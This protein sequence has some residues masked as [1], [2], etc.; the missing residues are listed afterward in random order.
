MAIRRYRL[1][2]ATDTRMAIPYTAAKQEFNLP[3]TEARTMI[4]STVAC[5]HCTFFMH[6]TRTTP[7]H[8]VCPNN[9]CPDKFDETCPQ[10]RS[11]NKEVKLSRVGLTAF[12]CLDCGQAWD[13][14]RSRHMPAGS[15]KV[16][17]LRFPNKRAG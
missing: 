9:Y 14:I 8:L 2:T 3:V 6:Q 15:A 1:K 12:A 10:C 13:S 5:P 4:L 16:A 17:V 7:P 11:G